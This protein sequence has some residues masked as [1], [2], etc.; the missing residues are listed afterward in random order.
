MS[1]RES[2]DAMIDARIE[3]DFYNDKREDRYFW[4][5]LHAA[6]SHFER[7]ACRDQ[8]G[9]IT[10]PGRGRPNFPFDLKKVL[11]PEKH[12]PE[13]ALCHLAYTR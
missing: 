9:K 7:H 5:S 2:K 12:A 11:N 1:P 13:E 10:G 4:N 8:N 3:I 6:H